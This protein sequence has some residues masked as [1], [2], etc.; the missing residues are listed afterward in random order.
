ML[1]SKT[2]LFPLLVA[3]AFFFVPVRLK[4]KKKKKT[5]TETCCYQ[6]MLPVKLKQDP[7]LNVGD[8]PEMQVEI[9]GL[10]ESQKKDSEAGQIAGNGK[11]C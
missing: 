1:D 7:T 4:E 5:K 8:N 2:S 10:L 3:L 11:V 9:L 6:K